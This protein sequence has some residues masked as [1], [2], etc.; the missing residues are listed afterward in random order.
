MRVIAGQFKGRTLK[1]PKHQGLRPT[2]DR[3][4]EA[5]FNII[6]VKIDD[7]DFL[8]LFAGTGGIGIEAY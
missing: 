3:V 2:A 6:G 8:D 4:K 7:A 5:L 1:G